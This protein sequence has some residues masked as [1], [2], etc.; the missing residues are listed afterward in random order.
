MAEL[1]L[2]AATFS[3][4][5]I[6]EYSSAGEFP[7]GIAAVMGRPPTMVHMWSCR[8]QAGFPKV[9]PE[10][11][12]IQ[13]DLIR[14][15]T[16]TATPEPAT[17]PALAEAAGLGDQNAV[18]AE[19]DKIVR[20]QIVPVPLDTL[21]AP[22]KETQSRDVLVHRRD[23]WFFARSGALP[24]QDFLFRLP[25]AVR[26]EAVIRWVCAGTGQIGERT[27]GEVK[28]RQTEASAA[29]LAEHA[30]HL[31]GLVDTAIETLAGSAD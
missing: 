4:K 19:I 20:P 7:G 2:G 15:P 9:A 26:F 30:E 23:A 22:Y 28:L 14:V 29:L 17:G 1:K 11:F 31:S 27:G 24:G 13:A 21:L 18:Q 16:V 25:T 6:A 10:R 3:L 12:K 8:K 5:P